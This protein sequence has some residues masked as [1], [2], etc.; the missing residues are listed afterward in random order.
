MSKRILWLLT[1]LVVASPWADAEDKSEKASSEPMNQGL[2]QEIVKAMA[3]ESNGEGGFLEFLY[4]GSV[5]YLISDAR[6]D[7]MRIISP[8]AEYA[9][10]PKEYIDNA[11]VSN[12]HSALDARYAV[13]DGV[14]YSVYVHPMSKLDKEQLQLAVYQVFSL[15]MTFGTEYSSGLMNYGGESAEPES[16][17]DSFI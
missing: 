9:D 7:R 1:L 4:Q 14:L 5:M 8:I 17:P 11:M 6:A 13:S 10:L 12:F 16:D 3:E 15:K 2:M